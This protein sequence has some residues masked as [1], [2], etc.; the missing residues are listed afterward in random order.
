MNNAQDHSLNKTTSKFRIKWE[1]TKKTWAFLRTCP[2][3][4]VFKQHI[5]ILSLYQSQFQTGE[6]ELV[7][8]RS[9]N[10]AEP[11]TRNVSK[12]HKTDLMVE[13]RPC[14]CSYHITTVSFSNA[15]FL[16][17]SN[18]RIFNSIT[19][20]GSE[21]SPWPPQANKAPRDDQLFPSN[22][23][24]EQEDSKIL[25]RSRDSKSKKAMATCHTQMSFDEK[26]KLS[27]KEGSRSKSSTAS[28]I[29]NSSSF[30]R[31]C[32]RLVKEQRARFYIMRRCVTMLIFELVGD[33]RNIVLKKI[34]SMISIKRHTIEIDVIIDVDSAKRRGLDRLRQ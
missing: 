9:K 6:S 10:E 13:E 17:E 1:L 28:L 15:K 11:K 33:G 29:R 22:D 25:M 7:Q 2:L 3:Y 18:F 14:T 20:W 19:I 26:W 12:K 32:A 30:T 5:Q 24:M 31:K 4:Q 16:I 34:R 21:I 23:P 27:R 8:N